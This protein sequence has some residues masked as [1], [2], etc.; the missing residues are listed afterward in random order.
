MLTLYVANFWI[1]GT[2]I[3]ALHNA[4]KTWFFGVALQVRIPLHQICQ[5]KWIWI[6]RMGASKIAHFKHLFWPMVCRGMGVWGTTPEPKQY[7]LA[8]CSSNTTILGTQKHLCWPLGGYSGMGVWSATPEPIQYFFVHC[9]HPH[10]RYSKISLVACGVQR[11]VRLGRHPRTQTI[12]FGILQF[13]HHHPRYPETPLLDYGGVQ[14]YG[15]LKRHPRTQTIFFGIVHCK[16]PRPRYPKTPFLVYGVQRCVRLGRHPRTQTKLL[17]V[18]GGDLAQDLRLSVYGRAAAQYQPHR[19]RPQQARFCF[20]V[21][22]PPGTTSPILGT[23]PTMPV[24]PL[25]CQ[26]VLCII[27]ASASPAGLS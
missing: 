12:F 1:L 10:P 18:I 20:I 8:F 19:K 5:Q 21:R 14:W 11:C 2:G 22:D 15:C 24:L 26:A 3:F 23:T 9:K 16:H 13:E 7:F 17:G 6:P 27:C 25:V 4:Y